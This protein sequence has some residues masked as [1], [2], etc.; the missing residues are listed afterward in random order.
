MKY[1]SKLLSMLLIGG[2]LFATGCTDYDQ[3]IK[4][5]NRELNEIN[6]QLNGRVNALAAD[7]DAVEAALQGAIDE[8]N[9]KVAE[10]K[11]AIEDLK[12]V[13]AEHDA[14][15]A[16]ANQ[17]IAD[18]IEDHNADIDAVYAKINEANEKITANET[19]IEGL[20]TKDAE[21]AKDIE[22]AL[23]AIQI[24]VDAIAENKEDIAK[25]Q[26]DLLDLS[27]SFTAY[28]ATIDAAIAGLESR[29]ETAEA[30]IDTLEGTVE[31][32]EKMQE[33]QAGRIDDLEK[34]YEEFK[35][36]TQDELAALTEADK[37]LEELIVNLEN[38]FIS[39]QQIV[40]NQ[41]ARA[42]DEIAAN[43]NAI[44]ALAAKHEEE[45][46][47][48][49]AQDTA[50]LNTLEMHRTWLVELEENLQAVADRVTA[51]ENEINSIKGQIAKIQTNIEQMQVTID[52]LTNDLA[53]LEKTLV[54]FQKQVNEQI[55][56][57]DAAIEKALAD[58]KVYADDAANAAVVK[59]K[60]YTDAVIEALT[61]S[62]ESELG[63]IRA[64]IDQL[65]AYAVT[66]E[67]ALNAYKESND[68]AID[69]LKGDIN[70]I[71]NR[72][73]S[74]VFVPE[75]SD[76]EATINY[77]YFG[78]TVIEGRSTL[79]YQVYP[80]ACAAFIA[81]EMLAYDVVGVS[82]RAGEA[83]TVVDVKGE[84][85][86]RLFVT[87]VAKLGHEFYNN[88]KKDFAAS[89]V[90][91]G[92][93]AN[94]STEYVGLYPGDSSRITMDIVYK[95]EVVTGKFDVDPL[96]LSYTDVAENPDFVA[97][98]GYELQFHLDG[99][100]YTKAELAEFG[101]VVEP[102]FAWT[103]VSNEAK[104]VKSTVS[105]NET[106][107]YN[108]INVDLEIDENLIGKTLNLVYTY[109]Y[110]AGT[111][112]A[113]IKAGSTLSITKEKATLHINPEFLATWT[114]MPDAY[115]DAAL[116]GDQ[117]DDVAA[118]MYE[119]IF[120]FNE[121]D[122]D[123]SDNFDKVNLPLAQLFAM[124]PV[125]ILVNGEA[126]TVEQIGLTATGN[127]GEI[128]FGNFAWDTEYE[129]A[130]KYELSNVD[131]VVTFNVLTVDR[132]RKAILIDLGSK[133]WNYASNLQLDKQIS[134]SLEDVINVLTSNHTNLGGTSAEEYMLQNFVT[135][136]YIA[137]QYTVNGNV[138]ENSRLVISDD[139]KVIY[140]AY[141]YA[142]PSVVVNGLMS[143]VLKYSKKV[144]TWYGQEFEFVKTLNLVDPGY[145]FEHVPQYVY[146]GV[147]RFETDVQPWYMPDDKYASQ[148][149]FFDV[150]QVDLN[151]AFDL[152]A[153]GVNFITIPVED[154]EDEKRGY[155]VDGNN[156]LQAVFSLENTVKDI[157]KE[158]TRKGILMYN[159]YISYYGTDDCVD[160]YATLYLVNENDTKYKFHTTNFDADFSKDVNDYS[161]YV[162][163][164]FD[165]IG[166]PKA[167]DI[168]Q[169]VDKVKVYD[170]DLTAAFSMKD[171]RGREMIN[172][173][174]GAENNTQGEEFLVSGDNNNG[175]EYDLYSGD[176]YGYWTRNAQGVVEDMDQLVPVEINFSWELPA[177]AQQLY[178]KRLLKFHK[179]AGMIE[180]RYTS[181]VELKTP[182]VIPVYMT[183]TTAWGEHQALAYVTIK[184]D[185]AADNE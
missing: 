181:E 3:D 95:G 37:A 40:N 139:A 50:I 106:T 1:L 57:L 105:M 119:R 135:N 185:V 132:V 82:T 63:D 149:N 65:N 20:K 179:E 67:E 47:S 115:V 17:A 174:R 162:V 150:K 137:E 72:I 85:N 16:E 28:Q 31:Q 147:N 111:L 126:A 153:D 4:D 130:V 124:E 86:G 29:V 87:V 41:F 26:N 129:V 74:I 7:L 143:D 100:D 99:K 165:P 10:N 6:D 9:Q 22:E 52:A 144:T 49:Q 163:N 94:L 128:Y 136:A 55:V 155:A 112:D 173:T 66:I 91:T 92:E 44:N 83:L 48:L 178:N 36:F 117:V 93:T 127:V 172:R 113:P 27:G 23:A 138:A 33:E 2:M 75:Y 156:L 148:L 183:A 141:D 53:E 107:G 76:G 80:A 116:L 145:W 122:A 15:I 151:A 51:N 120:G 168:E 24:N 97:L 12:A 71:L 134:D 118:P 11:E 142:D 167:Y 46:K 160:V 177:I 56:R 154:D 109:G 123:K 96:T 171:V 59:A 19:A 125:E 62:V 45:V 103:N 25:L 158:S 32:L 69:E 182:I 54:D 5:I 166:V 60:G 30:A 140:T 34:D 131:V 102:T 110:G 90:Y 68:K 108:E 35:Q 89:L 98:P 161:T 133:D 157:Y 14:A 184:K 58:A 159:N 152:T 176:I 64:S 39:Y 73:Q 104:T 78:S 164:K 101:Y 13:D 180:F 81:K 146:A 61:K 18:A 79:E 169:P 170:I 121:A 77:A 114:Y 70:K 88:Q 84:A 21:L 38:S 43:T 8:A 42:F 175:F